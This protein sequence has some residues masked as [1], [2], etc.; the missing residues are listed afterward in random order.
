LG[1]LGKKYWLQK[2]NHRFAI[3]SLAA[4]GYG[5]FI[6]G[7][8][9]SFYSEASQAADDCRFGHIERVI[10]ADPPSKVRTK[11]FAFPESLSG[12]Q[13]GEEEPLEIPQ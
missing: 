4:G 6:D 3:R 8:L 13:V 12:W 1:T 5:L 9:H 11:D 10:S 7:Q 2:G